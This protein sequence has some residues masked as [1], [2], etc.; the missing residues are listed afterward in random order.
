MLLS[1]LMA[2]STVAS[3]QEN[4]Y[5]SYTKG[6]YGE[7]QKILIRAAEK[8]PEDQYAFKP[9]DGV[10]SFG[11]LVS[12]VAE[13]QYYFC[14]RA[15]EEKSPGVKVEGV[16][17]TKADLVGALKDAFAYCDKAF[18]G[19]TDATG[20]KKVKFMGDDSPKLGILMINQMHMMEHYGNMVTY[21]RMKG[22]VPPTSEPG[23]PGAPQKK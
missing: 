19:I 23:M 9:T 22:I 6:V 2:A 3:A 14:S 15:A 13:S 18:A 7:L 21:L 17:T 12:H 20:A 5:S 10:R 11:Q 8:M 1:M 4:P 16:K